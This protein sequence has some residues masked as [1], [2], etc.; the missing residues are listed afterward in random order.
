LLQTTDNEIRNALHKKRLATYHKRKD[1]MVI[2]ELG[3]AH[4]ENRIDIA[5]AN[6]YIHGYEI[7]SSK[8]NL[9]RFSKQLSAYTKCFEK[10]TIVSAEVHVENV[11]Q[12]TPDWCGIV[13]V[14]KGS[15]G[16]IHFSTIRRSKKN[17]DI[18]IVAMAHFLWRNEVIDILTSIGANK[19]MLKGTRA[20][21]YKQ[22]SSLTTVAELSK[23]IK[24]YF[25]SREKWRAVPQ[26][27]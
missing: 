25:M 8:D 12:K 6:E 27:K 20:V 7:K 19:K 1:I 17:P 2:D 4:G 11:I 15:R 10:L 23:N 9:L 24:N 26:L 5:V 22:L 16:G 13:L 18:D 3:V 21:L 14:N